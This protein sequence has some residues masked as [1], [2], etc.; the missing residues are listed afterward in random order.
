MQLTILSWSKSNKTGLVTVLYMWLLYIHI[1][2]GCII[3]YVLQRSGAMNNENNYI[4]RENVRYIYP[5]K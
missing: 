5:I 1:I 2:L 3:P 4:Y